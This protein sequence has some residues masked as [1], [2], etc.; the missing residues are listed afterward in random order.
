MTH[1]LSRICCA[2]LTGWAA[3]ALL[4]SLLLVAQILPWGPD[5]RF[6]REAIAAG[7]WW[8]LLAAHLVHLNWTHLLLNSAGVLLIGALFGPCLRAVE[9]LLAT[10]L[11]SLLVGLGLYW[12]SPEIDWYVG[13]SGTLHALFVAGALRS[14]PNGRW[15]LALL[16]IKLIWEEWQGDAG[17]AALIGAA[18]VVDAH[19]Y[20]ALAG[21]LV[22][23]LPRPRNTG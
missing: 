14:G 1:A 11:G 21:L 6:E 9:W 17:T 4:L 12:L 15:L 5:W 7:Q 22:G 13:F 8:R 23:L 2:S 3:P 16:A 20:G 18:V 19:R 10:V